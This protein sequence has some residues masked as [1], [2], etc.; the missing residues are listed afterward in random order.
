MNDFQKELAFD[1][2]LKEKAL[3]KDNA[4]ASSRHKF[5]KKWLSIIKNIVIGLYFFFIPLIESPEWCLK[6]YSTHDI[7]DT[8]WTDYF[9]YDPFL[10]CELAV[11]GIVKFSG[12]PKTKPIISA[13][14]DVV[15]L[16]YLCTF[17]FYKM[18]WMRTTRKDKIEN[19]ILGV[20]ICICIFSN[21]KGVLEYNFTYINSMMRPIVIILFFPSIR[22]NLKVVLIDFKDSVMI[23]ISIL[24]TILYFAAMG[25]YMY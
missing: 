5:Q 24:I 12:I 4:K 14:F 8:K 18:T 3:I 22:A 9:N 6:Y 21:V 17:R 1:A 11:N 13:C 20:V 19:G 2:R 16:A 23:L 15:C 25:M 7:P 10:P